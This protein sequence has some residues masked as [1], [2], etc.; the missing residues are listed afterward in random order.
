[1]KLMYMAKRVRG[2]VLLPALWLSTGVKS[3]TVLDENKLKRVIGYL[4]RTRERCKVI[5]TD[6]MYFF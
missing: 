3:P 4:K 6:E 1:M 5:S 2:D